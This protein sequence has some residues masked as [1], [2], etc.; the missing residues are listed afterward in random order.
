MVSI[1]RFPDTLPTVMRTPFLFM[2]RSDTKGPQRAGLARAWHV[3][4]PSLSLAPQRH[5][6]ARP[7]PSAAATCQAT[8][9]RAGVLE[10]E[11]GHVLEPATH[12]LLVVEVGVAEFALKVNLFV[13]DGR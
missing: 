2:V 10:A 8:C 12:G 7:D 4:L 13:T 11:V 9:L 6:R 3:P 1:H 5:A